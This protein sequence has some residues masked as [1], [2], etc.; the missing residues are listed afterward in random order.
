MWNLMPVERVMG[1]KQNNMK[2]YGDLQL[3]AKNMKPT[4]WVLGEKI[5][6]LAS[7]LNCFLA[8]SL[9]LVER[10]QLPNPNLNPK[11]TGLFELV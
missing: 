3:I 9:I 10:F 1:P 4:L 5:F 2:N 7:F 8:L 6:L 11:S